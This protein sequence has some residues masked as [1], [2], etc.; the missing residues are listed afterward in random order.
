MTRRH[1]FTEPPEPIIC[2][3]CGRPIEPPADDPYFLTVRGKPY[4][5]VC[6]ENKILRKKPDPEGEAA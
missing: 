4:H 6:Y 3:Q 2:A 5:F 1:T